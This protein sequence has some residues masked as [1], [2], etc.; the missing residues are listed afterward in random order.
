MK[1]K[2]QTSFSVDPEEFQITDEVSVMLHPVKSTL[3]DLLQRRLP[4]PRAPTRP[5]SKPGGGGY[6]KE[7]GKLVT[8]ADEGDPGYIASQTEHGMAMMLACFYE[9][10]MSD[11]DV[12][13]DATEPSSNG[14]PEEW[15]A[16]YLALRAEMDAAG[17]S[18]V[19]LR[20]ASDRI[21]EMSGL[22]NAALEKEAQAFS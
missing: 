8:Q 9:S 14:S 11:P 19:T 22:S 1:I 18:L 2:G 10:T 7:N 4:A 21:M 6:L 13:F 5:V 17:L 3:I 20:R 16:F 12:V 15:K